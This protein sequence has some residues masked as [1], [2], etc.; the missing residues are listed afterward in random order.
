MQMF[1]LPITKPC[2]FIFIRNLFILRNLINEGR[3]QKIIHANMQFKIGIQLLLF[4]NNA[5]H[6]I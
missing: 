5:C 6:L 4:V 2:V 3:N 1:V